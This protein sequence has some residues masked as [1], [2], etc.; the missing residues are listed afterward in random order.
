MRLHLLAAL[1]LA[2][3]AM[4]AAAQERVE[5]R[6]DRLEQEMDAVQRRVFPG[7]GAE[8]F[9]PEIRPEV[10]TSVGGVPAGSALSDLTARVDALVREPQLVGRPA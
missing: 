9:Q 2:G 7:G 4:P 3:T 5:R 6:V 8:Y 10:S 1:L